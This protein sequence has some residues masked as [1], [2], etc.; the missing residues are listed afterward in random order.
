M[1]S[2]DLPGPPHVRGAVRHTA[3]QHWI[4]LPVMQFIIIQ[5]F[6]YF[7]TLRSAFL[8][9]P[10]PAWTRSC[11]VTRLLC[12]SLKKKNLKSRKTWFWGGKKKTFVGSGLRHAGDSKDLVITAAADSEEAHTLQRPVRLPLN[13]HHKSCNNK[14]RDRPLLHQS[15]RQA[16]SEQ[17]LMTF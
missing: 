11:T 10:G 4:E 16:A 12:T 6:I 15:Q 2:A 17:H 7:L 9:H 13:D 5:I 8:H 3:G 1:L 14:G